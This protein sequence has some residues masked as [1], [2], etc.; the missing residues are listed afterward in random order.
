MHP[1]FSTRGAQRRRLVS[2]TLRTREPTCVLQ[3]TVDA[4]AFAAL[5]EMVVRVC[6]TA[7]EYLRAVPPREDGTV[8]L[9]LCLRPAAMAAVADA[10]R[11]SFPAAEVRQVFNRT[12][13]VAQ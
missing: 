6:G 10:V 2:N 8:K 13:E 1:A 5:R 12:R 3:L 9:W 11:R 7:L 4:G